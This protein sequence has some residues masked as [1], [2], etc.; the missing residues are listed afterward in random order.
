[1]KMN[2]FMQALRRGSKAAL[3]SLGPGEFVVEGKKVV[4]PHCKNRVFDQG[5]AQLN[6]SGMTFVGLD[7]A[8][9]SAYTLL[10]KKCGHIEWFLSRPEKE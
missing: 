3:D 9:R 1:M 10:C 2:K 6:T 8:N 4:C 7:W 5:T